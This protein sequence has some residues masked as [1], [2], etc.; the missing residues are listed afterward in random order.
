MKITGI[1]ST[2]LMGILISTI[3]AQSF[4]FIPNDT[5]AHVDLDSMVQY[6]ST[7]SNISDST[8]TTEIIRM[9]NDLPEDWESIMCLGGLCYFQDTIITTLEWE[10]TVIF[11]LDVLTY[12]STSEGTGHIQI[13]VFNVNNPTEIV[14]VNFIATTDSLNPGPPNFATV[15]T[16]DDNA[17][18]AVELTLG[19][20]PDAT[21]G[22]DPDIDMY[23]PPVPPGGFDVALR[24]P[25]GTGDRFFTQILNGSLDDTVEHIFDIQLQYPDPPV[26]NLIWDNTEL[27]DLGNFT[28]VDPWGGDSVNVDMTTQSSLQMTNTYLT[29]LLLKVTPFPSE[30]WI[31]PS[32]QV[33]SLTAGWNI[34]STY[35]IPE[36]LDM[37]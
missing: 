1:I 4:T 5:I 26:I 30:I 19:F 15:I 2:M 17:G 32:S 27:P 10:D 20:S 3:L 31:E 24:W 29:I 21:D 33:I 28:L 35:F 22:Y 25:S 8:I 14:T 37:L 36:D 9:V 7:L 16:A 13:V 11:Q 18:V 23:A 12:N 6:E 34:F